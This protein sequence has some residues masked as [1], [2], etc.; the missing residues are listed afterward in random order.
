MGRVFRL[1]VLADLGGGSK[2]TPPSPP[3][4][5]A[6][7]LAKNTKKNLRS[8]P[9][10]STF[11][12]E[13][14]ERTPPRRGGTS[15]ERR[16]HQRWWGTGFI[17]AGLLHIHLW[18]FWLTV[19]SCITAD[20]IA[21]AFSIIQSVRFRCMCVKHIYEPL[22]GFPLP[23]VTWGHSCASRAHVPEVETPLWLVCIHCM[24]KAHAPEL[25]QSGYFVT[26]LWALLGRSGVYLE[27]SL[28]LFRLGHSSVAHAQLPP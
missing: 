10:Q 7:V 5:W 21:P 8:Y 19:A 2:R 20:S 17:K 9:W 18:Q 22:I 25:E 1:L 12:K 13:R 15:Q 26:Y 23:K 3:P 14:T 4:P 6:L 16:W 24:P 28:T 11:I 27:I